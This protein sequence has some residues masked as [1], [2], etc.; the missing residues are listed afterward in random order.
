MMTLLDLLDNEINARPSIRERFERFHAA[1][2]AVYY[3][4]EALAASVWNSGR[5]R[6]GIK[7]LFE[8]LRYSYWIRTS[9]DRFRLNNNFTAHYS[10]ALLAAHPEWEGLFELRDTG[11]T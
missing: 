3:E 11:E 8:V 4:L 9:G 7:T 2:P 6:I 1:N 10:R 5:R